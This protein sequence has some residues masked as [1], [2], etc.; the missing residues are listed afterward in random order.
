MIT[1]PDD[2]HPYKYPDG[3]YP[4]ESGSGSG[5]GTG[6]SWPG[7]G[8]DVWH[9]ENTPEGQE[10]YFTPDEEYWSHIEEDNR[11][12]GSQDNTPS[13]I[14][15]LKDF[16]SDACDSIKEMLADAVKDTVTESAEIAYQVFNKVSSIA[17]QYPGELQDVKN[18]LD[19]AGGYID[20][21]VET[22][23]NS[24]GWGDLFSIWLF[25]L[26]RSN[27]KINEKG[28]YI[29]YFGEDAFTTKD[30]QKQE[31]VLEAR[32]KVME[33]IRQNNLSHYHNTWT[34]DVPEFV[35]GVL[36]LNT[37]TSF[38]GSY[39]VDI[40]I[41]DNH[42]GTYTL[43][44]TVRNTTGWES[45][46]RLRKDGKD[47]NPYHDSIIKNCNRDTYIGLGGTMSEVWSWSET[48]SV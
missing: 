5:S 48:I 16:L 46:T 25:E 29:F 4:D 31:G 42:D 9:G 27:M 2:Y 38:L 44:Y 6:S 8:G 1:P 14:D 11:G 39:S 15:D 18:A 43:E 3:G 47:E 23:P 7:S 10:P 12:G 28:E 41:I 37:A 20:K 40:D 19:E 32:K 45:A 34:Y 13:I 17:T 24:I 30:L 36:E 22:D 26:D 35:D 21:I 33:Q